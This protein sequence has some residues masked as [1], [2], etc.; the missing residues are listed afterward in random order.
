[1]RGGMSDYNLGLAQDRHDERHCERCGDTVDYLSTRGFCDGCEAELD[2]EH[3]TWCGRAADVDDWGLC[4]ECANDDADAVANAAPPA[5]VAVVL[6]TVTVLLLAGLL[7][8]WDAPP[9]TGTHLILAPALILA[10]ATLLGRYVYVQCKRGG[11][12]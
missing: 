1:M 2:T 3:C 4:P 10:A 9:F 5:G 11:R 8:A 6:A 12:P 7:V